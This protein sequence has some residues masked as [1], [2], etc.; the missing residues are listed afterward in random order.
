MLIVYT[1]WFMFAKHLLIGG[2]ILKKAGQVS[3]S[4]IFYSIFLLF[5][6]IF[7]KIR[8][9]FFLKLIMTELLSIVNT[10]I[11]P[12]THLPLLPKKQ[13]YVNKPYIIF[14]F[15]KSSLS[16]IILLSGLISSCF[17]KTNKKCSDCFLS[18][19]FC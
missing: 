11:H 13:T 9:K 8:K 17:N 6:S 7:L 12:Y 2:I 15:S 5:L 10:S 3:N 16:I 19:L 4:L 14:S 18:F 1:I